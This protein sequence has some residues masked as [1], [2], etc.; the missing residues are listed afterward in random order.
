MRLLIAAV[1]CV[2]WMAQAR[3]GEVVDLTPYVRQD[4]YEWVKISPDGRHYA[5]TKP[6]EDRTA[7]LILRREDNTFTARIVGGV[8]SVVD[9]FWWANDERVV[10]SL[11]RKQGSRDEP[12]S[13]GELYAV[14]VDGKQSMLL[15]SPYG[16]TERPGMVSEIRTQLEQSVYML[17]PLEGDDR[18]VLVSA[19]PVASDPFIRIEKLDIYNRNRIRVADVPVRRARF[20]TD[21]S[22]EVRFAVGAGTD[23]VSKLFYREARG[24]QWRLVN[25]ESVSGVRRFPLGFS[26]DGRLAYLQV[27]QAQGPDAIVSWD[28]ADGR[29]VELLRDALVDPYRILYDMDGR[30]PIGASYMKEKIGN[31]FFDET[32]R[33]PRFYRS[34]E[35]VFAADA[36]RMT[37]ATRDGRFVLLFVWGDR[38]NG[39]YFLF[40]TQ[41]RKADRIFS[42]R[43]WFDPGE[44]PPSRLI[45]FRAR[46]GMLLHGY[47]T[48]PL[49]PADGPKP[50]VLLP[51]GGPFE[52]FDAWG[53]DDDAQ[54]LAAA[55]YA[56]LRV[57]YRGSGNYGRAYVAAGSR[58]WGGRMQDDLADATRWAI[59]QGIA[60]AG[61][62]C[63]YGA[64]Y[65]GYAALMGVAR[66]PGLYRCAAGYVGVYDLELMHRD[67]SQSSR[68]GRTWAA[69]WL[70]ERGTLAARSPSNLADRIKVPVFLAAGGKDERAP[71]EH[72]RRMEKAL[73]RAGVPVE[74][75]YYPNEGHGFY[76]EPHRR[77]YYA[78]LL[79]FLA[80]HLGGATAE[81][82]P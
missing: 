33:T 25:D 74:T 19:V 69:E 1:L 11:A 39:D 55:G 63:I 44:V 62:I 64:S 5:V 31:R 52:Y 17:D 23:N 45:S 73:R 30:T 80:R 36:V 61:R 32:A 53:F 10:M 50:M 58:E 4:V 15:A 38:N 12:V 28:P 76:T 56:V 68:S 26:A 54:L 6:L 42:R 47:L 18:N 8:D 7:L 34:L 70:G 81:R 51:H 49:H 22:G 21:Q 13:I 65:G 78:R 35:K 60:D 2:A 14:N 37:S 29:E 57:N 41:E 79:D 71:I 77:E 67:A 82:R 27:E 9:D 43:E 48:E 16:I 72:S 24:Q 40:D 20:V 3:A 46:D 75:L 59:D 66:D